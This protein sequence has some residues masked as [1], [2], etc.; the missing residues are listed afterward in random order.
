[1]L[2]VQQWVKELL[3]PKIASRREM[4]G[5]GNA[6]FLMTSSGKAGEG[7]K[8]PAG[9]CWLERG[10]SRCGILP[11]V[12][13]QTAPSEEG[14]TNKLHSSLRAPRCQPAHPATAHCASSRLSR[15]PGADVWAGN[16]G[17]Q[18]QRTH[19]VL[20]VPQHIPMRAQRDTQGRS[21]SISSAGTVLTAAAAATGSDP[22]AQNV[23]PGMLTGQ[24]SPAEVAPGTC[25]G[26][27][28]G[29]MGWPRLKNSL[30]CSLF[31][32]SVLRCQEGLPYHS[33]HCKT[34]SGEGG[35]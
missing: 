32:Q 13:Q 22:E 3:P 34:H 9:F 7:G 10:T 28:R 31:N 24:L 5:V 20:C 29:V 26:S 15:G 23:A 35:P 4:S 33:R 14:S 21:G 19:L 6:A 18:Q 8:T 27:D 17:T 2:R 12:W 16:G 25:G 11:F 1:M 30:G